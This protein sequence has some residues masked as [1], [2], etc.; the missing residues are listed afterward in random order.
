M[1]WNKTFLDYTPKNLKEGGTSGFTANIYNDKLY[2]INDWGSLISIS[3]NDGSS[4]R[5]YALPDKVY[6][7][8]SK[9]ELFEPSFKHQHMTISDDG[10]IFTSDGFRFLAFDV[11]V[12]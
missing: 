5:R 12:N 1:I 7:E 6:L 4:F 9:I 11:P 3:V 10:V 2:Y 8:N